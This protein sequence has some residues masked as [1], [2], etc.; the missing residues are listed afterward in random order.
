[1]PRVK[2]KYGTARVDETVS[3]ETLN[4]LNKLSELAYNAEKCTNCKKIMTEKDLK[5]GKKSKPKLCVTCFT[6]NG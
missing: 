6:V 5:F 1:M 4:A 3:D 2:L